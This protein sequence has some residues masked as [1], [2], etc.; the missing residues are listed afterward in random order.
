MK[1]SYTLNGANIVIG[2]YVKDLRSFERRYKEKKKDDMVGNY[3]P[4]A[5]DLLNQKWLVTKGPVRLS[6]MD[7]ENMQFETQNVRE[8]FINLERRGPKMRKD[9][10]EQLYMIIDGYEGIENQLEEIIDDKYISRNHL[11]TRL[12][13]LRGSYSSNLNNVRSFFQEN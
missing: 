1:K 4:Y 13:N 5:L 3:I 10:R 12:Y 9:A 11:K 2:E 8:D 6:V 7:L